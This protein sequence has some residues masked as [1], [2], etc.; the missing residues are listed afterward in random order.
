M[1]HLHAGNRSEMRPCDCCGGPG[2]R[3]LRHEK[4]LWRFCGKCYAALM[5]EEGEWEGDD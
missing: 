5:N 2:G 1:Y 3:W 4:A